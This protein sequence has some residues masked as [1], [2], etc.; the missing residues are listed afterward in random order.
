MLSST[1]LL[2]YLLTNETTVETRTFRLR[3][4]DVVATGVCKLVVAVVGVV[5]VALISARND[6]VVAPVD[7]VTLLGNTGRTVTLLKRTQVQDGA[8]ESGPLASVSQKGAVYF[9]R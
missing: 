7:D 8:K 4:A 3:I 6:A 2:A 1:Y 9:T 5:D